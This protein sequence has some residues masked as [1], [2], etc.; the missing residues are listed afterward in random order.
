MLVSELKAFLDRFRFHLSAFLVKRGYPA[1]R[2]S[3]YRAAFVFDYVGAGW[4]KYGAERFQERCQGNYVCTGSV[5]HKKGLAV[6][7]QQGLDLS[8][9]PFCVF[10]FSIA[11]TIALVHTLYCLKNGRMDTGVVVTPERAF[12]HQVRLFADALVSGGVK[13]S[14]NL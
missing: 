4:S 14:V 7:T 9:N 11:E 3:F 10:I 8:Q 13:Q 1:G 5:E 12:F 6:I 2:E